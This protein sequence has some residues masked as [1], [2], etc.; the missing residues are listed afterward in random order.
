[1]ELIFAAFA[2]TR[3]A[4]AVFKSLTSSLRKTVTTALLKSCF[5]STALRRSVLS[6]PK[7][8]AAVVLNSLAN[9]ETN[10]FTY[11]MD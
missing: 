10:I 3:T 5:S 4:V 2:A 7:T 9:S 11:K 8:T 6:F 1:L